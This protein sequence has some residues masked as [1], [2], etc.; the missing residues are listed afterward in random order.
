MN[1]TNLDDWLNS[2][3][4]DS[5]STQ[6]NPP[7][8][9][10]VETPVEE[11]QTQ[12][13]STQDFDDILHDYGF[14]P[15]EDAHAEEITEESS[16]GE[17]RE[18]VRNT[19]EFSIQAVQNPDF[20]IRAENSP[21]DININTEDLIALQEEVLRQYTQVA[22]DALMSIP[23]RNRI[24]ASDSD[25]LSTPPNEP[26]SV[27]S[28]T[29]SSD[30][31]TASTSNSPST[32][33]ESYPTIP[34]NSPTLLLD[35]ST[36]RFSGAEWYN[37]IQKKNIIIAGCGGIG[38]WTA[39]QLSR[40]HP[41]HMVLYDDDTVETVNMA[42]QLYARSDVG[43]SKVSAIYNMITAYTNMQ[44]IYALN[45]KFTDTSEPG[46]IMLCG[47]D[48]MSA[49]R[50]FFDAWHSHMLQYRTTEE[51]A[52]CLFLDGRLSLDTLQVFCVTGDNEYACDEYYNKH[53]FSDSEA[54]ATVCS[55]K[56]TTY[57]ACMIGSIMTN[58]FTN[59][60]ANLL[61]P[62]IPYDLPFFTE[63]DAQNMIFKTI[64]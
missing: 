16:R 41:A 58:L 46:D 32:D 13:L 30:S 5:P 6:Q 12:E 38:S 62:I 50:T 35:E 63:Y 2:L 14:T 17:E 23:T 29:V 33:I 15:P 31:V 55:V 60:C 18:E 59:F 53:L 3:G 34:L 56:Q 22:A 26:T 27:E 49:R 1:D 57:L 43:K 51:R 44:N 36:T 42:G 52:K 19:E 10:P 24:S 11:S 25:S 47:F 54:D 37:E 39:F 21:S 45:Q 48:S 61:N 7:E 64:T 8:E 9:V 20:E 4:L 40:M 28:S